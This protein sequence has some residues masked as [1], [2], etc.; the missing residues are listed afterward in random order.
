VYVDQFFYSAIFLHAPLG[1]GI[2]SLPLPSEDIILSLIS[3]EV[4]RQIVKILKGEEPSSDDDNDCITASFILE[5]CKRFLHQ[6]NFTT[7]AVVRD[8]ITPDKIMACVEN[9]LPKAASSTAI[10]ERSQYPKKESLR[11]VD[12]KII[13][14]AANYLS[15][16]RDSGV[17]S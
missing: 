16:S 13:V 11:P 8:S 6:H 4:L 12:S 1:K 10:A 15:V 14:E 9:H 7:C 17:A 5:S 3:S 2:T